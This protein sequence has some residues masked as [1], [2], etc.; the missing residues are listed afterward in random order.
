M[1]I[2]NAGLYSRDSASI[3]RHSFTPAQL[4]GICVDGGKAAFAEYVYGAALATN[5]YDRLSYLDASD[6]AAFA[7]EPAEI[8]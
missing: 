6:L 5:G 1:V 2:G 8:F 4:L 7:L 3:Y